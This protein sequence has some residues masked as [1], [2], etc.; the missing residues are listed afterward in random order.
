MRILVGALQFQEVGDP[1]EGL[2]NRGV[3][4]HGIRDGRAQPGEV[5]V[6]D[7][8]VVLGLGHLYGQ[9]VTFGRFPGAE[10][11]R[12]QTLR[13]HQ[14]RFRQHAPRKAHGHRV[15][16]LRGGQH[17]RRAV[18]PGPGVDE[19]PLLRVDHLEPA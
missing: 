1:V 13:V 6:I 7:Q 19:V 5:E 9:Q 8:L 14:V 10:G 17:H 4:I 2:V 12:G 15:F 18:Y 16:H 11:A 3:V